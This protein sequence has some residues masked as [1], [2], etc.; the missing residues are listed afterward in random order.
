[1]I[2]FP[3]L[4][5][6]PR[7]PQRGANRRAELDGSHV[8]CH[9]DPK[10]FDGFLSEMSIDGGFSHG[11]PEDYQIETRLP[12]PARWGTNTDPRGRQHLPP[13][14]PERHSP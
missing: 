2:Q 8:I 4:G 1:M 7:Q 3:K 13:S 9:L 5:V 6:T 10:R 11:L 12:K 14:I